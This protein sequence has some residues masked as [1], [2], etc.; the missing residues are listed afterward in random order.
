MKKIFLTL[1]AFFILCCENKEETVVLARV[2]TEVLTKDNLDSFFFFETLNKKDT[3]F[4]IESW[5]EQTLLINASKKEGLNKDALLIKKR[6]SY[7]NQLII[8]NYIENEAKKNINIDKTLVKDYFLENKK[9]FIRK[10]QGLLVE[11]YLLTNQKDAL[12]LKK[13]ILSKKNEKPPFLHFERKTEYIK[14]G[15]LHPKIDKVL[16]EKKDFLSGPV[17]IKEGY[18]LFKIIKRY[19]KGSQ[20][21]LEEVY[22]EIYQRLYK[23]KYSETKSLIIDKIKKE[24]DFFINQKFQ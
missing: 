19:E 13:F 22:D 12:K 14:R 16:F 20:K 4:L 6:N 2:G 1:L 18:N 21:G 15:R 8:S 11:H 10:E 9:E 3:S 7:F 24:T 23:K 5:V 17:K